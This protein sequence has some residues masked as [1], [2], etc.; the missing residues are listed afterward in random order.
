M[1]DRDELLRVARQV[2]E[3]VAW[4]E[5]G[6]VVGVPRQ[7]DVSVSAKVSESGSVSG[8]SGGLKMVR[9]ELGDCKRCKLHPMRKNIVFGVGN[10]EAP[11]VFVG[12]APGGD[13]DRTGEPSVG[14]AG[15]LL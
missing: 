3:H 11:L 5:R 8:G 14:A 1:S 10:P 2:K 15:Q 13:E 7:R 6:G 9:E 4:L 12:E